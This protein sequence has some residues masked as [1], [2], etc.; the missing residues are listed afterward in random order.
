MR[1][2]SILGGIVL[3]AAALGVATAATQTPTNTWICHTADRQSYVA[4]RVAK[5]QVRGHL[6]HGDVVVPAA[7]QN[8]AAARAFCRSLP[9]VTPLR[10]G[11]KLDATLT[12]VAPNTLGS[13]T[14]I[15][16]ASVTQQR[17]CWTLRFTMT[18]K[19]IEAIGPITAAHIHG[20]RPATDIV[21]P[22]TLSSK[23]LMELN[24]VLASGA[25]ARARDCQTNVAKAT[26]R[27]ILQNP[28]RYYVNVHTSTFPGGAL[29]GPLS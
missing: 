19:Q 29:Q 20:P 18:A 23:T 2:L 26:I 3:V 22:F 13:G 9:L 11:Q 4:I 1:R 14:A 5:S 12:P 24:E 28:D 10:G 21:V 7:S 8:R 27:A 16:R 6:R 15:V 17:L 25:T